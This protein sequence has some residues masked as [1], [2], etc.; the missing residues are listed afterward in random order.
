M[1]PTRRSADPRNIQLVWD[2]I[3]TLNAQNIPPDINR[4]V[5][6]MERVVHFSPAQAELYIKQV[7]E[8]ELIATTV[9]KP[10]AQDVIYRIPTENEVP[11]DDGYDWYCI[12]CHQAGEVL[13]CRECYRV[14]HKECSIQAS[15]KT[16]K[17]SSKKLTHPLRVDKPLPTTSTNPNPT[18]NGAAT[19]SNGESIIDKPDNNKDSAATEV[20]QP[21]SQEEEEK[22]PE[23]DKKEDEDDD[24]GEEK[25]KGYDVTLC[26]MCN[27]ARDSEDCGLSTEEMNLMLGFIIHR[28]KSWVPDRLTNSM[29]VE[30][31]PDWCTEAEVSWR[32]G[33]LF[34]QHMDMSVIELKLRTKQYTRMCDF[35][36]DVVTIQH[37]IAIFHGLESQESGAAN[38]MIIDCNHDISELKNC[39][40]CYKHSNEKINN[41]WFCF[42]CRKPHRL[43]WAKQKGYPYWP[44]KVLKESDT[45]C[46][47]RFFGGKYERSILAKTFIKPIDTSLSALQIKKSVLF[48]K[49]VEE[50]KLH[51]LLLD[52]PADVE[53]IMLL[54]SQPTKPVKPQGRKSISNTSITTPVSTNK[55]KSSESSSAQSAP[56]NRGRRKRSSVKKDTSMDAPPPDFEMNDGYVPNN[57]DFEEMINNRLPD[58]LVP[59]PSSSRKRKSSE[60]LSPP[61]TPEKVPNDVIDISDGDEFHPELNMNGLT[62]RYDGIEQVSSSTEAEYLR[63]NDDSFG[64]V[65]DSTDVTMQPL[66]QQYCDAVEKM[67]RKI[68]QCTDRDEMIKIAMDSMQQHVDTIVSTNNDH[69][70]TLFETHNQ[71]ISDTKKKQWCYY[72]EQDAIYHCC[73]NTAYCSPTC[74]QQH[75][76]T[77]HKKVCRRKRDATK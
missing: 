14:F 1:M 33:Q 62:Q 9:Q 49:A 63:A 74:Q 73:W 4:L 21:V 41:K 12:E 8:D 75:W 66:D 40:D 53:N 18:Q 68:E 47:V 35:Q 22:T 77:E 15:L 71:Q 61:E 38:L 54:N 52:N 20:K 3:R 36:A 19:Q 17:S 2:A 39:V 59:Q 6:F 65:R 67:R 31:K 26:C 56:S 13:A 58:E 24:D 11:P 45:T 25:K 69:L 16:Q 46:D 48:N 70:K 76:Q 51:R 55:R 30:T 32:S 5:N 29:N 64:P 37:N 10:G 23:D 44:A 57:N 27:L 60:V 50:L 43:V 34:Y 7:E 72:C 42:P 28:I